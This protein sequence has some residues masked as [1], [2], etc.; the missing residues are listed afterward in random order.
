MSP[1]RFACFPYSSA[2]SKRPSVIWTR[3]TAAVLCAPMSRLRTRISVPFPFPPGTDEEDGP[4]EGV[5]LGGHV[6]DH[7]PEPPG[8]R[9]VDD[10]PTQRSKRGQSASSSHSTGSWTVDR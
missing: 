4:L 9:R 10:L 7:L 6:A 8:E 3:E 5:A 1:A 2:T